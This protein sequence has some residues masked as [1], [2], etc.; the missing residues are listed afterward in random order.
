MNAVLVPTNPFN[1]EIIQVLAEK[2]SPEGN[3]ATNKSETF[4]LRN[5][6]DLRRSSSLEFSQTYPL[7]KRN[8][9]GRNAIRRSDSPA[10]RHVRRERSASNRPLLE[11]ATKLRSQG[12]S[13]P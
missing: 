1:V 12:Y 4:T 8:A 2:E 3:A 11:I 5:S 6:E 10:G 9:C 13:R 7:D